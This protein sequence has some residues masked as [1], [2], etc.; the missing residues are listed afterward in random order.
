MAALTSP[1]VAEETRGDPAMVETFT[2]RVGAATSESKVGE[3][4]QDGWISMRT[5]SSVSDAISRLQQEQVRL[6][7]DRDRWRLKYQQLQRQIIQIEQQRDWYQA[8][9]EDQKLL[10]KSLQIQLGEDLEFDEEDDPTSSN[11]ERLHQFDKDMQKKID[12]QVELLEKAKKDLADAR[13]EADDAQRGVITMFNEQKRY[14]SHIQRL[15]SHV[16]RANNA[17]DKMR[18]EAVSLRSKNNDLRDERSNLKR[19]LET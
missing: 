14:E 5:L 9:N 4:S 3:T 15:Q 10:I 19:Q 1:S 17:V 7:K 13:D 16:H 2:S 11:E 6:Q 8:D 18:T 12:K